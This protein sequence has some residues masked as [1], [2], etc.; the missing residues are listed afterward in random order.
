MASAKVFCSPAVGAAAGQDGSTQAAD[1]SK[2][3]RLVLKAAGPVVE[4]MSCGCAHCAAMEPALQQVAKVLQP[5]Q[6]FVRVNVALETGLAAR[7]DIKSTPTIV[8]FLG[9]QAVG[10]LEGPLPGALGAARPARPAPRPPPAG[11]ADRRRPAGAAHAPVADPPF[12]WR[13][14]VAATEAALRGG[15]H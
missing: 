1:G 12:A 8:L 15:P 2:F 9:G 13:V 14:P 7:Y 5:R 11:A 10:R 6:H 3:E 4:F